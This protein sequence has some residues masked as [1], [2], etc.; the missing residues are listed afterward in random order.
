MSI[1]LSSTSEFD[2]RASAYILD[3]QEVAQGVLEETPVF[4]CSPVNAYFVAGYDA[5]RDA[6]RD[7]DTYSNRA[8][9]G[10]P[11]PDR[12]RDRI[13]DGWARVAQLVHG[14]QLINTDAPEHIRQ[15]RAVQRAFT[16][17]RVAAI[18]PTIE[19]IANDLIDGLIDRGSC[20]VMRDFGLELTVRV[21]GTMLGMPA[22]VIPGFL[23]WTADVIAVLAPVGLAPEDIT[24]PDD[25]LVATFERLQSA[26]H[27]YLR[28]L[29]ER[30][31]SPGD[32]VC[33]AMLAMTDDD[34]R[35]ALSTDQVL[36]HMVGITVA[37][38]DTTASLITA[39]VIHLTRN[40]A[41]RDLLLDD[42][43][44]WDNAVQEGLRRS[45][46]A[47]HSLRVSTRD[48]VLGGVPI[49]AGSWVW[50]G[51]AAANA[52]PAHFEDPLRFDIT[53]SN[54]RDHVGLGLGRHY[55]LGAPL[56]PQEARIALECLYRRLPGLRADLEQEQEFVPSPVARIPVSQQVNW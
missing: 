29:E 49:P 2:P 5:V 15:R 41:Q 25:Q 21:T 13:P 46:N 24:T 54:A 1:A 44:L 28:L 9:K 38:T 26:Y 37:G 14:N 32:D 3:P 48:S 56:A 31:E 45:G 42:P 7:A 10:L 17:K 23:A 53:R 18:R 20:D 55:C 35:P 8:Y 51:L 33:S 39:M 30:R 11:V 19:L 27:Q 52:D 47:L 6:L 50:V 4:F 16:P 36:A 34:G 43:A 12:L 22:E 40:P